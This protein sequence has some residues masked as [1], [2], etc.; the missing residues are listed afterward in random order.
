VVV[1]GWHGPAFD[2]PRIG[3]LDNDRAVVRRLEARPSMHRVAALGLILWSS[4]AHAETGE[5][6]TGKE[7]P[8]LGEDEQLYSCKSKT[9]EVAVQFKPEMEVKELLT[10]VM[11]FTCKN[12]VLDPRIVST[13]RRVTIVAPNKMTAEDA[14][15][16]FLTSLST[17]GYTLVPMGKV[18][19]VVESKFAKAETLPFVKKPDG[20]T[21]VRY[22]YRPT[23]AQAESL[24]QALSQLKSEAGDVQ[25]VGGMLLITD[26]GSHVRD[27]LTLGK[28]VDVPKGSDGLYLLPVKHADA[29]KLREKLD[30]LLG[31]QANAQPA[32]KDPKAPPSPV[33]VAVPSKILVDERTNTLIIAA[34]AN[35]YERVKAL[36]GGIDIPLEIEGGASIHVYRLGSSIAEEL[37]KTLEQAV[38]TGR[39]QQQPAARPGTTP[40]PPA[41]SGPMEALGSAIE[42]QV[43]VIAD[44]PT[45]SLIVLS[46]GR[47][48]MALKEII[49]QLDIPRRQVYIETVILEVSEGSGLD[50]GT[51][52]HGGLPGLG[53]MLLG[54]VQLPSL[55]SLALGTGAAGVPNGLAG[56]LL[57]KELPGSQS[58][59]GKS[60]PSYGVLFQ[61][62]ANNDRAR[63]VT[64]PSIIGIDNEETNHRAGTNI[65]YERGSS[66]FT[67]GGV[68]TQN[69][70]ERKPLELKLWIKPHVFVDDQ[71]MIELKLDSEDLGGEDKLKQPIWTNRN[72]ETRVIVRDQQ[73]VVV[74][75]MTQER[76]INQATKVPLLG[77]VP[78]LGH[79]FKYTRREKRKTK[80]LVMMT[81]FIVKDHLDLQMMVDRKLREAREFSGS[82]TALDQAKYTPR[83][84]Y[85]RKRG[86]LEDINRTIGAIEDDVAARSS[87]RQPPAVKPGPVEYGSD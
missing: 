36:V 82:F 15:R 30:Q 45:N 47:D 42:G 39:A 67:N 7:V 63:V 44:K 2:P 85:T 73:T 51:S 32:A 13:Q 49:R 40:P 52:S 56:A 53:G 3:H 23:Y 43:R 70:I 50:F 14:Y 81:P 1:P 26:Y 74:G 59:F 4:V 83:I 10:W 22:V 31:L 64:A 29:T 54:G 62:L 33:A 37:A 27:M 19:K 11:G 68:V 75:G 71:V 72:I 24:V 86:L 48:Y 66:Q 80:L 9:G 77:D 41:P 58:L 79:L 8:A 55:S 28:L 38:G 69:N 34:S 61:A 18:V 46:S 78:I 17:V 12:F 60:I 76:E 21:V 6:R 35:A 87:L 5:T 20:D 57:G 16:L 25:L 65:S 84:D